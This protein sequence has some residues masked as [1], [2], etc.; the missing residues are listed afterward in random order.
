[1]KQMQ[2]RDGLQVLIPTQLLPLSPSS[3]E[4]LGPMLAP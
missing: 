4:T 3:M 1:M 2:L